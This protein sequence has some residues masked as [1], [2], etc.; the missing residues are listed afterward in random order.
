MV[1][2]GKKQGET[3]KAKLYKAEANIRQSKHWLRQ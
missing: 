1:K 2:E 3:G